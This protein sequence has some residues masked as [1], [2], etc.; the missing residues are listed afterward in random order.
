MLEARVAGGNYLKTRGEEVVWPVLAAVLDQDWGLL[1]VE[2]YEREDLLL[3]VQTTGDDL[4]Q[5]GRRSEV[6]LV[7]RSSLEGQVD[8]VQRDTVQGQEPKELWPALD[9]RLTGGSCHS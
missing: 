8:T 1:T 3:E 4:Q 7:D 9:C 6:G 2:G 5:M